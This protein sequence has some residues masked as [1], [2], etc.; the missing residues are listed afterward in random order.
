[1]GWDPSHILNK[2]QLWEHK[3]SKTAALADIYEECLLG[4]GVINQMLFSVMI[5]ASN[6]YENKA[7]RIKWL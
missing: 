1:M 7:I 6:V 5:L 4:E 2:S 3:Q